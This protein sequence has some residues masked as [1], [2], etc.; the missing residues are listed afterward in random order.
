ML[1]AYALISPLSCIL[2]PY[3]SGA[4]LFEKIQKY[5]PSPGRYLSGRVNINV[6]TPG[7][8]L[9][10]NPLKAIVA[11]P[12]LIRPLIVDPYKLSHPVSL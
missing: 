2:H 10:A 1:L 5:I 7:V 8:P 6:S 3:A 4:M 9:N 11:I 12:L